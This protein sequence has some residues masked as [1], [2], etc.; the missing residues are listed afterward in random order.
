MLDVKNYL[1]NDEDI[2]EES[3]EFELGSYIIYLA[4]NSLVK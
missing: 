1:D 4:D 2:N 3:L